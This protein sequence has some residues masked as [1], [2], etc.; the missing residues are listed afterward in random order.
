MIPAHLSFEKTPQQILM[1]SR[2]MSKM[3]AQCLACIMMFGVDSIEQMDCDGIVQH[4]L[5]SGI[6]NQ[7]Q[8]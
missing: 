5:L 7:S 2:V 6:Q 4:T 1:R 8:S 3:R